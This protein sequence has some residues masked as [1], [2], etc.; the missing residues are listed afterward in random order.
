MLCC[1]H[2]SSKMYSRNSCQ[3][4]LV[5]LAIGSLASGPSSAVVV[6][7]NKKPDMSATRLQSREA[8]VIDS[9]NT[10]TCGMYDVNHKD[11]E[12]VS[13]AREGQFPWIA[14]LQ[15]KV[16]EKST[17]KSEQ[18]EAATEKKSTSKKVHH[19]NLED[20]HFCSGSFISDKW[21]LS[22][23]HCFD[24]P[25]ITNYLKNDKL[26]VVAG[27]HKVSSKSPLNANFSIERVYMHSQFDKSNPVGF[28]IALVEL[29]ERVNFTQKRKLSDA[30][31]QSGP[32]INTICLP[33]KD[34]H[35]KFNE[36]ARLAGWGLS[37]AKDVSSMPTKLLTTDILLSKAEDCVEKYVKSLKSNRPRKQKKKYDDFICASYKTTRDACQ[38]DS[39]GP[40]MQYASKKA[41]VTGIVSYGVGCA[42]KGVPGLYTR[43]SAYIDWIKDITKNGKSAS[44]G[45]KIIE[46]KPRSASDDSRD[47]SKSVSSSD[48]EHSTTSQPKSQPTKSSSTTTRPND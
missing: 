8:N 16:L 14:S 18:L 33:L 15:I 23:A 47:S 37:D 6:D 31:E 7:G 9:F 43:T 17:S 36:T 10:K 42:T 5:I 11:H 41:V 19:K 20:L 46:A 1:L 40:L 24:S 26:K 39:G 32:F 4:L 44:V 35:Y 30:G 48:H 12:F 45:F 22:A 13:M 28:D 3:L 38:S 29:R 27:S 21:I 25:T 2:K 34:K